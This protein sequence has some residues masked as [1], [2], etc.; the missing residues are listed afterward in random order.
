MKRYLILLFAALVI[1]GCGASVKKDPAGGPA[2]RGATTATV[3]LLAS[4][5]K[6]SEQGIMFGHQDDLAYGTTW[7]YP[8]GE[9]D[10]KSVAGDYPALF[11][12]DMGHMEHGS[13]VNLDSVPFEDM[14]AFV[15][16]IDS[17][18][19]IITFSWHLDNPL[20]GGNAWDVSDKNTVAS[21]LP[22]G[23]QNEMYCQWLDRL[24]EWFLSLKESNGDPVP[25]IF[26]PFHEH[27]GSW[28]WW[29]QTLCTADQYKGLWR[30][31]VDY[32]RNTKG[33]HN[34]LYA[35]STSGD[36]SD[37]GQYLERYPGDDYV[38][39]LG[40]DYYQDNSQGGGRYITE[41]NSLLG[42]LTEIAGQHGKLPALTETG[43][44]SVSDP[45]W[46]TGTLWPAVRDHRISYLLV[47][48]NAHNRPG[49]YYAPFPGQQSADDFVTF[50]ALP[51]TLFLKD[52]E[53]LRKDN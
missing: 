11:G 49:H 31:T 43:L 6:M 5:K 10:V 7:I 19:G 25:V 51:Q 1:A 23:K 16:A 45:Q 37:S 38:D 2:D 29:G 48:R 46:W 52:V 50:T 26:R 14:R 15:R 24:A 36:I 27:T 40:F 18:G 28:F 53:E 8:S 9:S 20:T 22:G 47:W 39:I 44:E 17:M 12:M 3:K 33:V 42:L 21:V 34:L 13:P 30:F 41:V 35:Y 4:M 32:L